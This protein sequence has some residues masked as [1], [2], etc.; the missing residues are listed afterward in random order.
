[1]DRSRSLM[2]AVLSIVSVGG[3]LLLS[4]CAPD[5]QPSPTA[6]TAPETPAPEPYAGPMHFVGDELDWFLL[7]A[8]EIS[9]MIPGSS[10]ITE[11]SA[12][13]QQVSD[14]HGSELA[15]QVCGVLLSEASLGSIGARSITWSSPAGD[16]R[17]GAFHVLQ[18]AN[19]TQAQNRMDD[20]AAAAAACADFTLNGQAS[21]YVNT[22][23][24]EADGVRAIAGALVLDYGTEGEE[25]RSYYGVSSVGNVLV[26]FWQP[27]D[28]ESALDTAAAAQLLKD[29]AAQA[30]EKLVDELTANPPVEREDTAADPAAA[31]SEWEIGFDGVGPLRLGEDIE[32][33]V[34]AAPGAEAVAPGG[35]FGEW[36]LTAQGGGAR[37]FVSPVEEGTAVASIRAGGIALYGEAPVDG[38][39]LPRAGGVGI[40]D[41]VTDAIA[42]FPG[43]NTVHVIAAGL[44]FYEVSTRDG[45]VLLFHADRAVSE[46]GAKIIGITVEDATLRREYTL[47]V[48]G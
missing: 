4:A 14:G 46:A 40:G 15:P 21:S 13:L 19:E 18:F 32:T 24:D 48:N 25:Y 8:D 6:T 44:D 26:E 39:V 42:A 43:G 29:R 11:P 36:E 5:P 35:G 9:A 31:W 45:R 38:A 41:E 33:V 2:T 27:F 16:D 17:E 7:S 20:Y 10:E 3:I 28:G 23:V 47:A 22:V 34:A 37:L 12:S 1:M 30:A